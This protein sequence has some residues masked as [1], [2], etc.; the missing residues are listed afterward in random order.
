MKGRDQRFWL[1]LPH[2]IG[3]KHMGQKIHGE[4][5]RL[6]EQGGEKRLG[7]DAYIIGPVFCNYPCS[8]F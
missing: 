3:L 1:C 5:L 6:P 7:K 2:S 8:R 4:H